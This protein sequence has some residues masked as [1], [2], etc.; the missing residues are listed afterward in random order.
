MVISMMRMES[1]KTD[2]LFKQ[3]NK[4]KDPSNMSDLEKK[5]LPNIEC[6]DTVEINK[7][8]DVTINIGSGLDHPSEQ[9]HFIQWIELSRGNCDIT[10]EYLQPVFSMPR[11]TFR[12]RLDK[13]TKLVV[14]ESCNLHGIWENI[15]EIKVR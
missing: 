13:D 1:F 2:D 14:R 3:I 7:P 10:R 12:I 6:P 8:F 9:A 15:K 5:H 4:P 11:V